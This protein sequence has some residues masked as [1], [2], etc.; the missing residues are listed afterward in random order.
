MLTPMYLDVLPASIMEMY[1]QYMQT[2]INDIARRLAS[3]PVTPTAA[4]QL[5]RLTE[6]GA[7][8]ENALREIAK[9][10]GRSEKELK[11]L[12]EQAGVKSLRFDDAIYKAAGL[13][14]LPLN[15]SPVM[16]QVLAAGLQKT[17]DI[18][19]NLV[20]TTAISAQ[21][22]FI[23]ASDIAYLQVTTGTF[24]YNTAIR[25]AIKSIGQSGLPVIYP[26]G[27]VDKLDVA[28]RRAVLTG[29]S[30]TAGKLQESRMDELGVDLVQVSAHAG[31]R[32][33]H[34]VWQGGIYSRSGRD[35]KYPDFVS[36]TGY[37]TV[38]GLQGVN[39]RHS[40][41]PFFKGISK[42]AYDQATRNQEDSKTV[43]V[44]GETMSLYEATQIQRS[45]ER[46]IREWKRQAE[47][48]E[49]AGLDATFENAKIRDWQAQMRDFIRQSGLS[50]QYV[51]E[52]I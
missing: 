16:A 28:M 26:S 47:A 23:R 31:A 24:D 40:W 50:R 52:Q 29:V 4:W 22:S 6:S 49:S 8:Y 27:R 34:Q 21:Q 25:G 44:N 32:P 11:T 9:L 13:K 7:V 20:R 43:T 38:T 14:P 17:N 5:Q 19:L 42:N 33:S 41:Y 10:T 35:S 36:S 39:C 37:G 18:M 2:V 12:F 30:Q 3:M 1:E 46:K 15:M 48:L 51:R 45:Y